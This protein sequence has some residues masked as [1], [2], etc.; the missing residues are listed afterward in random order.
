MT[1]RRPV[2]RHAVQPVVGRVGRTRAD[3]LPGDIEVVDA[4][5]VPG[6][7][8]TAGGF[9]LRLVREPDGL[10]GVEKEVCL[11][12]SRKEE[13]GDFCYGDGEIRFWREARQ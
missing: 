11:R 4:A 8:A 5:V 13:D 6:R 12:D 1:P 3:G 7:E 10:K 2:E 9:G